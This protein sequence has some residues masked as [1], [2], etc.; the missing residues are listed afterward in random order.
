MT[1]T[2]R[3]LLE[4]TEKALNRINETVSVEMSEPEMV[5]GLSEAVTPVGRLDATIG[6]SKS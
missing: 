2:A 5:V 6:S 4:Q 1:S 3:D